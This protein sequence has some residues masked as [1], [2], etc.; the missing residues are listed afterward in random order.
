[1]TAPSLCFLLVL[2]LLFGSGFEPRRL[3]TILVKSFL[4]NSGASF[5][6]RFVP[7]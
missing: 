7:I 2:S 3:R 5:M 6:V 4:S 1:M